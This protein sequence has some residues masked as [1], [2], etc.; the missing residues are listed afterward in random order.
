M[1][2][3]KMSDRQIKS[4]LAKGSVLTPYEDHDKFYGRILLVI[5]IQ[6]QNDSGLRYYYRTNMMQNCDRRESLPVKELKDIHGHKKLCKH[7]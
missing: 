3:D 2:L 1:H 7:E 5:Q 6:A 4:S